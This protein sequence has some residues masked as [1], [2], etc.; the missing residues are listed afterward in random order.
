M[1]AYNLVPAQTVTQG[2]KERKA[3]RQ[4]IIEA[5]WAR[6]KELYKRFHKKMQLQANSE[7]I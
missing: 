7:M 3:A 6:R 2:V 5:V 1:T 4:K